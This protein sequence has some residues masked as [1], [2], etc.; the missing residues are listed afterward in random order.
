[1][2]AALDDLTNEIALSFDFFEN[3]NEKTVSE[4]YLSGGGVLFTGI[5]E[6]FAQQL[7]KPTFVWNPAEAMDVRVGGPASA[8]LQTDPSQF[9]ICVGLAARALR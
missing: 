9:A 4:I 2:H 6:I 8:K 7:G 5:E 1:M 3:E